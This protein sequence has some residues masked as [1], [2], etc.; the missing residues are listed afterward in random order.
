M[1]SRWSLPLVLLLLL[2]CA[3]VCILPASGRAQSLFSR[4]HRKAA[5]ASKLAIGEQSFI[6]AGQTLEFY[7]IYLL[8]SQENGTAV[9][10]LTVTPG[11][12]A[13]TASTVEV[14][15]AVLP[16]TIP[17]MLS[18]ENPCS[19]PW[20]AL[21][22]EA[23]R[24]KD[25][26]I[27]GGEH[28]TMEVACHKSTHLIHFEILDRDIFEPHPDT[29]KYTARTFQILKQVDSTLGDN[30]LN[31]PAFPTG[32]QTSEPLPPPSPELNDLANGTFDELFDEAPDKPSAIYKRTR[33]PRRLPTVAITQSTP[34][35]PL[36]PKLPDYPAAAKTAHI[37]GDVTIHLNIGSD[38]ITKNVS[39]VSGSSIL[40]RGTLETANQWQFPKQSQNTSVNAT[41]S[42]RM[43]CSAIPQP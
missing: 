7:Q 10:R 40:Q 8:T 31:R 19:I 9:K 30:V 34:I 16:V 23:T 13:C 29:P 2:A 4:F 20:K 17:Q 3:Q 42:Y 28:I 24:C 14:A 26:I 25:C 11:H 36:T 22:K 27:S 35:A 5:P 21:R 12:D 39:T 15:Q 1:R 43:N 38:G 37:D 41:V 18:Y 32:E 33:E 6:D